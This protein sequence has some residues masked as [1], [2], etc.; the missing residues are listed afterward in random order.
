MIY[1]KYKWHLHNNAILTIS[2]LQNKITNLQ[3]NTQSQTDSERK[4]ICWFT[5][6][7][8]QFIFNFYT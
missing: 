2:N 7:W 5:G 6:I 4:S 3:R 8:N 1:A